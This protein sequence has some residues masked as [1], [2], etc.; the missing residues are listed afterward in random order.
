MSVDMGRVYRHTA[1]HEIL[2]I[3]QRIQANWSTVTLRAVYAVKIEHSVRRIDT[4]SIKGEVRRVEGQ[5][6]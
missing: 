6:Y 3:C 4:A 5:T 1:V 2:R